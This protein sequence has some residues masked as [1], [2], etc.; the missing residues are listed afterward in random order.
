[1][2]KVNYSRDKDIKNYLNTLWKFKYLKHGRKNIS[3]DIAKQFPQDFLYSLKK[4]KNK[5]EAIKFLSTFLQFQHPF[6]FEYLNRVVKNL[7]I[8]LDEK[9]K[10]IIR[11]L[12][13]IYCKKFPFNRINIYLTTLK[14]CPYD[15]K[16][17]WFMVSIY[18]DRNNHLATTLHE[19]N[20]F[21]FYYYFSHL[22]EEIGKEKFESLKEALTVFTNPEEKGYPAQ[23]KLRAWLKSQKETIPEIIKKE[24]WRKLV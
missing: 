12:E 18:G 23:Q 2:F 9:E 15:F 19:L 14:I 6:L 1:M 24:D 7:Q 4:I 16:D 21:M 8:F 17:K 5:K 11:K 22:Q 20:H 13:N 10:E 3:N